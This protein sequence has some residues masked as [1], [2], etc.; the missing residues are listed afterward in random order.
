MSFLSRYPNMP[1]ND[2]L[3]EI[4][5]V[6]IIDGTVAGTPRGAST[7]V[8][9]C[10]GE[11]TDCTYGVA[12]DANG[13]VTTSPRPVEIEGGDFEELV[14]GWD[15]TIGEFGGDGG[16]GFLACKN[17]TFAR[18]LVVPTNIASSQGVRLY[19]ELPT[20]RSATDPTPVVEI[21]GVTIRAGTEF[22]S[23]NN[24]VRL[25]ASVTFLG[26]A[27]YTSGVDGA[28]T[29]AGA[30]A[31]FQTF[32]SAGGLFTT[33][34]RPDGKTGVKV[35]DILVLGVVGGAGALGA[36][37]YTLR[38]RSV[39]GATALVVEKLDGTTFDWTTGT[40][41]PWRLYAGAVADTGLETHVGTQA[42]YKIPARPLDA[43]IAINTTL[44]PT[45]QADPTAPTADNWAPL[46][47]LKLRSATVTG[48][49]YTATVQGV[50][51]VNDATIDALYTLAIAALLEDNDPVNQVTTIWAARSS[52]GIRDQLSSAVRKRYGNGRGMQAHYS[53]ALDVVSKTVALSNTYPGVGAL[54]SRE[55][56]F[57]WPGVK[58]FL[59]EAVGF[60]VKRADGTFTTDGQL[61]TTSDGWAVSVASSLPPEKNP[62][63][64]SDAVQSVLA[65]WISL[66]TG[67][68]PGLDRGFYKRAKALGMM[69]PRISRSNGGR[70]LNY[71]ESGVT[72]SINAANGETEYRERRFSFYVQDS[73]AAIVA[74]F[75]KQELTKKL[76]GDMVSAVA[77]WLQVLKDD[78]RCV[79]FTIDAISGNNAKL[80]KLGIYVIKVVVE[81]NSDLRVAVL[82]TRV[83]VGAL[84]S[85]EVSFNQRAA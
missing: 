14:G 63:E 16:S 44:T 67:V 58:T 68:G 40:A 55:M 80:R 49:V 36:N 25:A 24:R 31:A 64:E 8:A 57:N 76:Q 18:L 51:A 79:D 61:D 74:P 17:K 77:E 21:S 62:G 15:E 12:I 85:T 42:G 26:S 72:A 35:G 83:G 47:G 20:N 9:A 1:S 52:Q 22:K 69:A 65:P 34:I 59:K 37:A 54:R 78:G 2:V 30:P 6:V 38:V 27:E 41:Q 11:F 48:I 10:V 13:V 53:P 5:G 7:G 70:I 23:G 45:V 82:D 75:S 3:S 84:P 4:E 19:R 46:S 39:T 66:Q 33:F 71:F 43:T 73:M 81:M 32:N 29:A 28:M 50:N 60:S 56:A